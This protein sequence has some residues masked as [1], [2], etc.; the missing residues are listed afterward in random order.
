MTEF[1]RID[2]WKDPAKSELESLIPIC[3]P[4]F[5]LDLHEV[6]DILTKTIQKYAQKTNSI[7]EIGCGTGRN[8]V[9]LYKEGF[10]NLRGIEVSKRA[11]E[12]GYEAFP[13][14]RQIMIFV[15]PV[16]DIIMA[17]KPVDVIFT[18]GLLMHLPYDLDWVLE[19]IS[20]KAR[21]LIVI[22]E[23]EIASKAVHYWRR[24]YQKVFEDLGWIQIETTTGEAYSDLLVSTTKRVFARRDIV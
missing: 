11:I 7:L 12:V 16:E 9:S 15:A 14:Y 6:S 2:F 23:D 4:E 5:Y 13:E 24:D 3:K 1:E 8:L 20:R 17:V 10:T 21:N 22:N 18:S 19:A